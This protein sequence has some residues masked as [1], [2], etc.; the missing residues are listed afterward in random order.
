MYCFGINKQHCFSFKLAS[1]GKCKFKAEIPHWFSFLAVPLKK[2]R[3]KRHSRLKN[4][5]IPVSS[6]FH[7]KDPS[8][9][10]K[11][12]YFFDFN[13]IALKAAL[14]F[15]VFSSKSNIVSVSNLIHLKNANPR[16]QTHESSD[17]NLISQC[18][19]FF[20]RSAGYQVFFRLF[21]APIWCLIHSRRSFNARLVRKLFWLSEE[22]EFHL[23]RRKRDEKN[24]KE[25]GESNMA[26]AASV[27]CLRWLL[28]LLFYYAYTKY[29]TDD[30][31][32]ARSLNEL[33]SLLRL[34]FFSN[35]K[36]FFAW[37]H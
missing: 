7:V 5:I 35:T 15:I 8:W 24:E 29:G 21:L 32:F 1:L 3:F 6:L 11:T 30:I 36:L 17:F 34:F 23:Q 27:R 25:C 37:L 2:I 26:T 9:R 19:C 22:K 33:W 20:S 4:Y 14:S 28:R 10:L 16:L 12:Q 18:R 31:I 13:L